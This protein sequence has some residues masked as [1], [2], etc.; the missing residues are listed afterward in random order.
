MGQNYL[1][2]NKGYVG[3]RFNVR[4]R[5]YVL[6]HDVKRL[7]VTLPAAY[8]KYTSYYMAK[9][10]FFQQYPFD[11]IRQKDRYLITR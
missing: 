2:I 7:V 3:Y 1:T 4:R 10:F 8:V 6:M 5:R 11:I 9:I